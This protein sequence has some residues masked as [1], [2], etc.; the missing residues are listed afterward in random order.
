[1]TA[2]TLYVAEPRA[3]W[4]ARPPVVADCSVLAA[5]LFA[6]AQSDDAMALLAQRAVH[7]PTLLPFE[8]AS[9]GL[10]K[11]RAGATQAEVDAALTDFAEQ[12]IE[13]HPAP[14]A[15]VSALAA[16]YSLSA[17]DAAYLWLAAEL[18]APLL[19]FD[20]RLARAAQRH[21]ARP[22]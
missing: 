18:D 17:Y 11:R 9:V 2:R 5:M 19:T 21:L 4:L 16:Q 20:Q 3:L 15:A 14:A 13:L 10:K 8:M 1:L 12:R 7:A 22:E 6:E